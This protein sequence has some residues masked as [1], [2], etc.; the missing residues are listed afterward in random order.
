M[1]RTLLRAMI[2]FFPVCLA[3]AFSV[4][5]FLRK[6]TKA[7]LFELFGAACLMLV[8]MAHV[9]EALGLFPW[10]HWGLERSPGHYLDL[11]SAIVGLTLFLIG[12]SIH[13]LQL[14]RQHRSVR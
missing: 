4:V 7:S 12:L 2:A 11:V 1:N 3:L 13:L 5:S 9:C 10:M 6:S 14:R 8:V